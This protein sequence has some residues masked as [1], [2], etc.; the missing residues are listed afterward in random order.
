MKT[1]AARRRDVE[2]LTKLVKIIGLASPDEVIAVCSRVWVP[3]TR[4]AWSDCQVAVAELVGPDPRMIWPLIYLVARRLV[5][6]VV[7]VACSDERN[8]VEIAALRHEL[9]VLRR[10]GSPTEDQPGGRL[11]LSALAQRLVA[12][13]NSTLRL[14]MAF[15]HAAVLVDQPAED[16]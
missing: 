10:P 7:L 2:D 16:G 4:P 5:E 9:V 14:T 1:L 15:T 6:L 3:K 8:Q 13:E 11:L 12:L